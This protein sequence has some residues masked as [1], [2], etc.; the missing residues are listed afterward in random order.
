MDK[1]AIT[2]MFLGILVVVGGFIWAVYD[3]IKWIR[4]HK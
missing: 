3:F 2:F 4:R 1:A